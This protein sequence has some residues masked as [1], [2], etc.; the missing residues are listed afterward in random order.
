MTE[1]EIEDKCNF[2]GEFCTCRTNQNTFKRGS[3]YQRTKQPEKKPVMYKKD[4]PQSGRSKSHLLTNTGE[5]QLKCEICSKVFTR[6]GHLKTHMLTH[7]GE[8]PFK[9]DICSIRFNQSGH[10]KKYMFTHTG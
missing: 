7:T 5:K 4:S 3:V 9:C 6:N 1:M 8:K 10:L 2:C